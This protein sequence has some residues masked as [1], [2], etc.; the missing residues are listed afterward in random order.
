MN[1]VFGEGKA[2][3]LHRFLYSSDFRLLMY[4]CG[5]RLYFVRPGYPVY[6]SLYDGYVWME[7]FGDPGFR[8]HVAGL[9]CLY[10]SCASLLMKYVLRHVREK[11]IFFLWIILVEALAAPPRGRG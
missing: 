10:C 7:K 6:H 11:N 8:R 3:D 5:W 2:P 9:T 1:I 4:V